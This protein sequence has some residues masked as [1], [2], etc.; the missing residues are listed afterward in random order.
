MIWSG[1]FCNQKMGVKISGD[2]VV[3]QHGFQFDHHVFD[4]QFTFFHTL[5]GKH[6]MDRCRRDAH[7]SL[8]KVA[9]FRA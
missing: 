1:F 5:Q 7:E 3:D 8:V 2:D 9:V 6:V 4:D